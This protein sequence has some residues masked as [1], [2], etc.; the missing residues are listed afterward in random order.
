L[1]LWLQPGGHADGDADVAAVAL[2][3]A[4]EET[5]LAGLQLEAAAV[6]DLDIHRIPARKDVPEHDHYDVRFVIRA[7]GA[8]DFV[9]TGES[10][11]L[12]WASIHEIE[13]YT[14]DPSILRLREK[15]RRRRL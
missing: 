5:G 8:E 1:N 3:E 4:M 15:W 6:F 9:V 10:H 7:T 11:A 2:R 12:A 14:R 13:S